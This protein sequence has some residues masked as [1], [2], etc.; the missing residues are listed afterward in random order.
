MDF[1][2]MSSEQ[3]FFSGIRSYGTTQLVGGVLSFGEVQSGKSGVV[4]GG[5]GICAFHFA[6]LIKYAR[7]SPSE[8]VCFIFYGGIYDTQREKRYIKKIYFPFP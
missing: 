4:V 3:C 5:G 2:Y 7:E 1:V 6:N 8:P